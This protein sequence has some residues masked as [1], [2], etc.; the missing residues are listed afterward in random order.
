[1]T[2]GPSDKFVAEDH[3]KVEG[4]PKVS[5]YEV[6]V[7]EIGFAFDIDKDIKILEYGDQDAEDQGK[8]CAVKTKWRR[9]GK[10]RFVDALRTSSF[11][12]VHVGDKDAD[13]C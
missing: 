8:I 12:E 2:S 4:D 6:L 1:M 9:I 3:D 5:G 13:P 7:V 11:D 10:F